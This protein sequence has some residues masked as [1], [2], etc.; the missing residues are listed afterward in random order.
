VFSEAATHSHF[1]SATY[2]PPAII[3][4]CRRMTDH[5]EVANRSRMDWQ[6][7]I[8]RGYAVF[9][10]VVEHHGG[11]VTADLDARTLTFDSPIPT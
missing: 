7:A 4:M 8:L 6:L 2:I 3:K 10:S 5:L 11:V 1:Q 9:R